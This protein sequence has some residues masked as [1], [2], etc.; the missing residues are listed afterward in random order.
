[1]K[2]FFKMVFASIFGVFIA[3]VLAMLV[4]IGLISS[5]TQSAVSSFEEKGPSIENGGVLLIDLSGEIGDRSQE[6]PFEGLNIQG[7]SS[8]GRLGLNDI[9]SAL[10]KAKTDDRIKG[11]LINNENISTS[12]ATLNEVI[13]ALQD[14]KTSGKFIW[15]YAEYYSQGAYFLASVADKIYMMPKGEVD[16]RGLRSEL[17][18]FKGTL[19]K[20]GVEPQIIRGSDN[21]FKSAAETFMYDKM[22]AENR[23]QIE[24]FLGGIWNT[25]VDLISTSRNI[26]VVELNKIADE[27]RLENAQ[28]AVENGFVDSLIYKDELQAQL[29]ET[30]GV[31]VGGKDKIPLIGVASYKKSKGDDDT[32]KSELSIKNKIA[33]IY[34]TGEINSGK[35]DDESIG[36]ETLSKAIREAREDEKVKAIVLRVNSPGG[37]ALASEVILREMELAKKEKPIVVSMGDVAASGGYYIACKANKIYASPTTITGS[38]GVFALMFRVDEFMDDKLGVTFDRVKTNEN[39]DFGSATRELTPFEKVKLQRSVDDIYGT[40]K[41]HVA[42]GRNMTMENVSEIAKGRV[43]VGTD[44]KKIGLVDEFGGLNDA[45]AEAV[46]LAE[47][48]EYKI[49]ELPKQENLFSKFLGD[50]TD[51]SKVWLAKEL[52]GPQYQSFVWLN[53]VDSWETMQVRIPLIY[54]IE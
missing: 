39:S 18:F 11:V 49:V 17:M 12:F 40:F 48:E 7:L 19:D 54:S 34:A 21:E 5:A 2:Q 53:K 27:V 9:L 24:A 41:K 6:N 8:S 29:R 20:L 10:E 32:S 43:W 47:V 35:G 13:V 1:M 15:A 16:F 28:A 33:V 52:F 30:L 46:R 37:S 4:T 50:V 51:E 23:S 26:S 42:D 31:G 38:I 14:F 3:F 36:S 22:S 45:I 25:Y 44:A